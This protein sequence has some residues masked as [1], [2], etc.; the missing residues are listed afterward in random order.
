M[1][2]KRLKPSERPKKRYLAFELKT[3]NDIN[4]IYTAISP[5]KAE[6]GEASIRI[7]KDKYN[8]Y[9]HKGILKV[10]NKYAKQIVGALNH[11]QDLKTLGMSGILRVAEQKYLKVAS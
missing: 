10:N 6:F 7:L 1:V 8:P 9:S 2:K 5:A 11:T 3:G 4:A